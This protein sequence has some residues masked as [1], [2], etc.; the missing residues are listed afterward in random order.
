MRLSFTG[1]TGD[2]DNWW[3]GGLG[4]TV[5]DSNVPDAVIIPKMWNDY[6]YFPNRIIG[7]L[8]GIARPWIIPEIGR[9]HV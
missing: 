8:Y 3:Y 6:Y 4:T 9:A 7:G 1:I 2:S 5:G